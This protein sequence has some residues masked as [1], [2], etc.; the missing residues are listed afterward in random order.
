MDDMTEETRQFIYQQIMNTTKYLQTVE[1]PVHTSIVCM[2][3][4]A[5]E[6]MRLQPEY[7]E[8]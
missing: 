1:I 7:K 2:L 5:S 3:W 6:L 4:M 8:S